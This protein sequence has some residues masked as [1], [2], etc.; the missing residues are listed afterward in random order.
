M[1]LRWLALL[2][3]AALMTSCR[4]R[5]TSLPSQLAS[6]DTLAAWP[7]AAGQVAH[8][9][10]AA[11]SV[12]L[13]Q[14]LLEADPIWAGAMGD[15]RFLDRLPDER[16]EAYEARRQ[17]VLALQ[18][19]A[20]ALDPE[21]LSGDDRVTREL[22]LEELARQ[23]ILL[24]ARLWEWAVDPRGAA[25]ISLQNLVEDQPTATEAQRE[26]LAR[27]WARM[28]AFIDQTIAN[29]RRG[30]SAGRVAN[31]TSLERTIEQ[32][33][34][35]LEQPVAEWTQARPALPAQL[36]AAEAQRLHSALQAGL[37]NELRPALE[38]FRG[39]LREEL[40][41]RARSDGQPGLASLP[42]GTGLYGRLIELHTGLPLTAAELHAIGLAEI[43]RIRAEISTLGL[44]VF[45][46]AN[47]AEIQRRLREDPALH[48]AA[49]EEVQATAE[50]ALRRAES[51]V[52]CCF[53]LR[54]AAAC[55]VV[56]IPEHEER[57]TTIAYYRQP[58]SDG[59]Q[60]G[61]Y[62][63][64]THAP[65]TRPRYEAEVLAF[66]EAV[67]GHH[68]Q[69][70]IAQEREGLPRFRRESG[71]TAYVEGWALYT[72]R[73]CDEMGL[74][75]GDL[76]RFGILSFDAWRA[77]R[78]VVDTGL[79]ALGWSRA[80][81]L[82]YLLNN[83]LLASNNVENEVDRYIAWPGQALAYKVGQ[84][85]IMA[86]REQARAA[87]GPRFTLPG[88]HDVVLAHGAVSL[89]VLRRQVETWIQTL[90]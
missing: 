88:F 67:P 13:W 40:L 76:D 74:Y 58:A 2:L 70:A 71:V 42:G 15:E 53:G 3:L 47:V 62:F 30:L 10:L 50:A 43:A 20:L 90:R 46:T 54:P 66:H 75:S 7:D 14:E 77:A 31:R 41:P 80:D 28:P 44:R 34:R 27:R 19:R 22:L 52:G 25:H 12:E 45:G 64:N 69:I 72:E 79:H 89:P 32:L 1:S 36:P 5:N 8:P 56:R 21:L 68:L 11:L 61:R 83:T 26:A 87:L 86:L 33:D 48:F 84:R 39:L 82:D 6:Q 9:Q 85:E 81:A 4:D 73:L 78:L 29:L 51:S 57:D 63:V 24:E 49:R 16:P 35:L 18:Q 55:L 65:E 23:L 60:P 17:R 37:Q 59:S 38:R